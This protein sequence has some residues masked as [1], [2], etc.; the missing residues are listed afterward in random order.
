MRQLT[1]EEIEQRARDAL[2]DAFGAANTSD[3]A[4]AVK[5]LDNDE[6]SESPEGVLYS[7]I[8]FNSRAD[9]YQIEAWVMADLMEKMSV[10][11]HHSN[12]TM[13]LKRL[14]VSKNGL[15]RMEKVKIFT[16]DNK[17]D[18]K[19]LLKRLTTPNNGGMK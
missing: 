14:N 7:K 15:G 10:M 5:L 2:N 12:P 4:E 6:F 13:M 9:P 3:R 11:P 18:E 1:P 8:D 19:N 16:G 17:E